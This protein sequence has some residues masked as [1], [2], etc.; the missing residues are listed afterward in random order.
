MK[1]YKA[2]V[3]VESEVTIR[4]NPYV[5]TNTLIEEFSECIFRV[6]TIEELVEF[7]SACITREERSFIEGIGRV[8]YDYG[9]EWE[10]DVIMLYTISVDVSTKIVD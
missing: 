5:N 7:A 2:A 10:D 4:I 8:E 3:V 9:Q 1:T 6:E